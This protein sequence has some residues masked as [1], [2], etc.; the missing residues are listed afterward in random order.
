[1]TRRKQKGA[2][3]IELLVVIVV[4]LV[5]I[6]A[7]LQAFPPGLAILR[8]TRANTQGESL[9]RAEMERIQA[10]SS[11]L[12]EMIVPV[13]YRFTGSGVEVTIDA[14]RQTGDLMPAQGVAGGRIRANGDVEVDGN[15]I[16]PWQLVSGPNL[17]NRVI[18]EGRPVPGPTVV[19]TQLQSILQ[20]RFAPIY[21]TGGLGILSVYGNDMVRQFG[22]PWGGRSR[23]QNQFFYV[24]SD[25]TNDDT[26]PGEDQIWVAPFERR[27]FRIQYSFTY[28]FGGIPGTYDVIIPVVLDPAAPP[29]F[30]QQGVVDGEPRNF[31]V[32]S[33]PRLVGQ[34]DINGNPS[35]YTTGTWIGSDGSSVRM[36]RLYEQ[37]PAA[38]PFDPANPYQ[39]RVL[40]AF[41]GT[42]SINPAA[43][44]AVEVL[45]NGGRAPLFARADYTVY[46]WRIIRDEF[47]IPQA[48]PFTRKLIL[49]GVQPR[50]SLGADLRNYGGL[51]FNTPDVTGALGSQDFVLMDV[52]TGGIILGNEVND[53][54]AAGFPQFPDSGYGV[55]KTTG[56]V[57]FRD[58][59][60]GTPGLQMW[61]AYPTGNAASPWSPRTQ[62][63]AAGRQVRA[64]Y[65]GALNQSVQ[66]FTAAASYRVAYRIGAAGLGAGEC[67][68]GGTLSGIGS[69]TR[70]YFPPSDRGQKV[71]IGELWYRSSGGFLDVAYEQEFQIDAIEPGLG[72]AYL[73]IS[74]KLPGATFDTALGYAVRRVRG[75]SMKV[76]VLW[77]P[78]SFRLSND[79]ADNYNRLEEWMRSYRRIET[80]SF[81][82][83]G[84]DR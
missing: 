84:T 30:A 29:A 13:Q 51:G 58:V 26:F 11:L 28:D 6:L 5:G 34:P 52:A 25:D 43:A 10:Q 9:A 65:R 50:Q 78:A 17:F 14:N 73:D 77:N 70:L 76:R 8:Q 27:S 81:S 39:F 38:T 21:T 24:E 20:L 4:F 56:Y 67:Y 54:N 23:G 80:Q 55:Q 33:L 18:G 62:I 44:S 49:N 2:S 37:L 68:V 75:A 72:L 71:I 66:P 19:G 22:V 48:A 69:P 42:L 3:L 57:E 79:T 83:R 15:P 63:D 41:G 40:S 60:P 46:D 53:P 1:M 12:P 61:I 36:Q 16:G 31:W 7:L 74:T 82:V 59:N 32:I 35:P 45:P 47:R 64:L